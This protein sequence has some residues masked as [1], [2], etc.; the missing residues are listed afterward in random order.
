MKKLL[1]TGTSGFLGWNICNSANKDWEIF[2]TVF[3]NPVE[4]TGAKI[5][6]IDLT[7]FEELKKIFREINPDAVIHTAAATDP[8]YCQKNRAETYKINVDASRN[9]A[10]LCSDKGIQCIFTSTDLVFDGLNAPYREEDPVSPINIY[11]EQKVKA[12]EGVLKRY[13]DAAVCR[14]PLMFGDPGPAASSFFKTMINA[15]KGGKELRLFL[16]EY[17]TPIG[18]KTAAGGL[19]L[20]IEKVK[21]II[22]LGGRERISRYDFGLLMTDIIGIHKTRLVPCRQKEMVMAAPRSPDVSLDSSKAFALG[23][24]PLPLREELRKL[25]NGIV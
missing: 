4:I 24:N 7:N 12:E 20:V 18:G 9:I 6:R 1:V 22:H 13:P 5:V 19:L 14:M 25:L 23:F 3:S 16:D 10:G 17:R 11:G 21:G 15:L 2:G 8:N